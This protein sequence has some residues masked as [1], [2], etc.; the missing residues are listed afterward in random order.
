METNLAR[1]NPKRKRSGDPLPGCEL[2]YIESDTNLDVGCF[3]AL[4]GA[5]RH[6]ILTVGVPGRSWALLGA[7][8]RFWALQLDIGWPRMSLDIP[9]R[10]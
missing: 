3:W 1:G 5:P 10:F 4:L 8:G 7:L 9:R 6:S 2:I